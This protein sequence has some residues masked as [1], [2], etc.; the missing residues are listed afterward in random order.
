MPKERYTKI[1]NF[2]TPRVGDTMKTLGF[3]K[4]LLIGIEQTN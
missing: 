3:I 1:V 2:I 4:T